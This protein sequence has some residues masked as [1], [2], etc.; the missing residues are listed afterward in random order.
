[1][2]MNNN[3]SFT[4]RFF[5]GF[6]DTTILATVALI[7]FLVY[8]LTLSQSNVLNH[9]INFLT[10]YICYLLFYSAILVLYNVYFV[11]KFGGTLGKL[12]MGIRIVD[13]NTE[14]FIRKR[15]AFFRYTAG[16]MFSSQ[17]IGLGFMKILKHPAKLAWHDEL[18][19]TKVVSVKSALPG[20][21]ALTVLL[22]ANVV[23]FAFSF[24]IG[25]D[26][27]L[28]ILMPFFM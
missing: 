25:Y 21:V 9:T 6:L 28:P 8:V 4:K 14:N 2:K 22:V 17:F 7:P 11:S 23:I 18:F 16:Y 1:M 27:L 10:Y 15:T 26:K 13:Q 19:N 24:K 12:L 3:A 5:A 20:I